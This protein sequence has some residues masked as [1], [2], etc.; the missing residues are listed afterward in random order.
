MLESNP[1]VVVS[2]ILFMSGKSTENVRNIPEILM[3][4]L[5][6]LGFKYKPDESMFQRIQEM[7]IEKEHSIL[8]TLCFDLNVK[9]PYRYILNIARSLNF[10]RR[11][12]HI[13]WGIVNELMLHAVFSQMDEVAIAVTVL[14]IAVESMGEQ[15]QPKI[16]NWHVIFRVPDVQLSRLLTLANETIPATATSSRN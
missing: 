12:V 3:V 13:A 1:V 16:Q 11:V 15:S 9:L 6:L 10:S 7:L 2:S 4:V 8:R 5:R 14:Y